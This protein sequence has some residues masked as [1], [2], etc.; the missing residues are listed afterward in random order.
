MTSHI[1]T[2][3]VAGCVG[4]RPRP[5]LRDRRRTLCVAVVD[6]ELPYP[7]N[8]GKRIRTLNLLLPL[9]KRHQI[10]YLAHQSPDADETAQAATFLQDQGIKPVLL[11]RR[12]PGKS[13]AA[14][15]ARL[16]VNLLS[17]LPYSVQ[18]HNSTRLRLAIRRHAAAE[19]VDLWHCEWTPYAQSLCSAVRTPWIVMAHNVESLIWERYWQTETNPWRRWY[20]R[21]QWHKFERFERRVFALADQVIAV[22]QQ[23]A[24]LARDRFGAERVAV[25]DNGVDTAYFCPD[26]SARERRSVLFLGSLD[27]RPNQDAVQVLLD[28]I[29]PAVLQHEPLAR[30]VVAGRKPP[31]WLVEKVRAC[32][33]A[34]LDAD[35]PDVRPLLRRCGLMAVPLRVG[36]GSRLKILEAL[37]TECP[38]VSTR[39]GAEGLALVRDKHYIQVESAEQMVSDLVASIRN[40]QPVSYTHLTLPTIYSV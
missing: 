4:S 11:D 35:L 1:E 32:P 26:G 3:H 40:P 19:P 16:L 15:F 24:A 7:A 10:T 8:S 17:P 5:S 39:I 13:G 29:F 6:E 21:R 20:I 38:V 36:G 25:V 27:W 22:S 14:F 37:A 9:A 33:N 30:L 12:V 23:D 2:A 18:V 34:V 31:P 28:R